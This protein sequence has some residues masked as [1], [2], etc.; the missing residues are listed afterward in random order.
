MENIS[1]DKRKQV[2]LLHFAHLSVPWYVPLIEK[3]LDWVPR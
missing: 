3:L 2:F 1:F